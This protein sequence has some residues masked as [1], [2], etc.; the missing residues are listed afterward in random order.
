MFL[1]KHPVRFYS[2]D[3]DAGSKGGENQ[4]GDK[5]GKQTTDAD[6]D[7]MSPDEVRALA[8]NALES[9]RSANAEAKGFREQRD[10]LQTEKDDAAKKASDAEKTTADKYAE[11]TATIESM[12]VQQKS[13]ELKQR[14]TTE[15]LSDGFP[16]KIV[17]LGVKDLTDGNYSDSMKAFKKDFADYKV[18][19]DDKRPDHM[20]HR[21][22]PDGTPQKLLDVSRLHELGWKHSI[23]LREGVESTYRWFLDNLESGLRGVK[24]S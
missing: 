17:D 6:V 23:D 24:A 2:S 13:M 10:T 9:K 14:A 7:K 8:K 3:D 22:K 20:A 18:K 16:A 19:P 5:G 15:L 11:A 21:P 12:K 4:E 1:L